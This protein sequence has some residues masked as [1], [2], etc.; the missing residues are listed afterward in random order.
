MR[1]GL[2]LHRETPEGVSKLNR[3]KR[4]ILA[5]IGTDDLLEDP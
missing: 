3:I 2:G 1:G 5:R 4:P